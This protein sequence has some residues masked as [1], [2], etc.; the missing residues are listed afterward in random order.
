MDQI[1]DEQIRQAALEMDTELG[2]YIPAD[3]HNSSD[4]AGYRSLF[5]GLRVLYF[6]YKTMSPEQV[7]EYFIDYY[8]APGDEKNSFVVS[9]NNRILDAEKQKELSDVMNQDDRIDMLVKT[10]ELLRDGQTP[11]GRIAAAQYL[12]ALEHGDYPEPDTDLSEALTQVD[13]YDNEEILNRQEAEFLRR[14][15]ERRLQRENQPTFEALSPEEV[16]S[17][18]LRGSGLV[19]PG[20]RNS[21]FRVDRDVDVE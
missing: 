10:Y 7:R 11:E 2:L 3:I 19:D 9:L 20:A 5:F 16:A 12:Y 8:N 13:S 4:I 21:G 18:Y 14:D 1:T 6:V 15:M 17:K